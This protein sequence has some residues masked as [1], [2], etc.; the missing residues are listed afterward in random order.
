MESYRAACRQRLGLQ[1][2]LSVMQASPFYIAAQF[3]QPKSK[4]TSKP[5]S[6]V[7]SSK[8]PQTQERANLSTAPG[9]SR[10]SAPRRPWAAWSRPRQPPRKATA[11][12]IPTT[13]TVACSF[14]CCLRPMHTD[15]S[16][17]NHLWMLGGLSRFKHAVPITRATP[18]SLGPAPDIGS[19]RSN[20]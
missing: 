8:K 5:Q 1:T 19:K 15:C 11:T 16:D 18:T 6:A 13:E 4:T 2:S 3:R 12:G 10:T 20:K 17:S 14:R 9:S 7:P